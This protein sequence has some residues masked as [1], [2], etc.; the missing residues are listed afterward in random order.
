MSSP[1]TASKVLPLHLYGALQAWGAPGVRTARLIEDAPT[2]SALVG[3]MAAALGRKR[4]SDN[5]DLAALTLAV[6]RD[7]RELGRL[8]DFHLVARPSD[9]SSNITHREYMQ[10][11][12][13]TAFVTG[14]DELVETVH[15]ALQEPVFDVGLGRRNCVPTCPVGLWQPL[16]CTLDEAINNYWPYY[17]D[18]NMGRHMVWRDSQPGESFMLKSDQPLGERK[19]HMRTVTT[20]VVERTAEIQT[21]SDGSKN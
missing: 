10:W 17:T 7:R 12:G 3:L 9:D 19:F 1:T 21:L 15:A 11:A 5:S 4:G 18:A 20:E 8:W 14:N 2:K 13:F 16:T 6:R